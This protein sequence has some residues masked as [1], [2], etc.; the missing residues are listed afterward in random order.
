MAEQ[1]KENAGAENT[2]PKAEGKKTTKAEQAKENAGTTEK[3]YRFKSANKFLTCA[4]LGVQFIDG[5][6]TTTNVEVAKA[7]V[8]IDGVELVEE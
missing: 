1:A 8:K 4:G 3:V 5:S 2:A 6:A 7:L